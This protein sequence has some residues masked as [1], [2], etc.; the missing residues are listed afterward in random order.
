MAWEEEEDEEDDDGADCEVGEAAGGGP[1]GRPA[2]LEGVLDGHGLWRRSRGR[3]VLVYIDNIEFVEAV[4][5]AVVWFVAHAPGVSWRGG[6]WR[7]GV[8]G[9]VRKG[10]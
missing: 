5:V 3:G 10:V 6:R 4:G 1:E 7:R 9:C 8:L 2:R